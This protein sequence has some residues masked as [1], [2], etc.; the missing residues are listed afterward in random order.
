MKKSDFK[1][2]IKEEI[3][4]ILSE[5]LQDT[6]LNQIETGHYLVKYTTENR[7]GAGGELEYEFVDKDKLSDVN[8]YNFW[9]SV[10]KE[11]N[12]FGRG[13]KVTSVEKI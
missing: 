1:K 13:D 10:A 9:R 3:K 5:N 8:S 4:K 7:D 2:L 12:L 11:D 6:P